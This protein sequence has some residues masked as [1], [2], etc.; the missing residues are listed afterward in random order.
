MSQYRA[1]YRIA[2]ETPDT[3]FI[4]DL[5]QGK[6]ITNDAE[7]VVERVVHDHGTVRIIYRDTMGRWDELVHEGGIFKGF[8]PYAGP[9]P[10]AP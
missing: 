1:Q 3:I 6:S 2:H 5:D 10:S 8:A 9:T 4:V 7:K